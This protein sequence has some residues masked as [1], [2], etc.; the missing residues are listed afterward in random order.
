MNLLTSLTRLS[1]IADS[2]SSLKTIK[3]APE[4]PP[5]AG[6]DQLAPLLNYDVSTSK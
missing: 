4:A 6:H 1:G 2:D 5:A 3:L